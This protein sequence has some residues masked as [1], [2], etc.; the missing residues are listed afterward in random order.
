MTHVRDTKL[1]R[2]GPAPS[3]M[4]WGG[5]A[6]GF[7]LLEI[8]VV[9]ALMFVV[10]GMVINITPQIIRTA[11][12]SSSTLQVKSFLGKVREAAVTR[13]RNIE[14][15]FE[16]PNRLT[17]EERPI[18]GVPVSADRF[19]ETIT[20]EGNLEYVK[21]ADIP[22]TP[23]LFGMAAAV[24]TNGAAMVLFTSEGTFTD[25]NGDFVNVTLGF[26]RPNEPLTANAITI[27]G[28]TA[29]VRHWRWNGTRWNQ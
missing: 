28:T 7:T 26:A 12:G 5:A 3:Q 27:L 17:A 13:R 19:L 18:A 1:G 2:N 14:L 22:D 4:A 24:N 25:V 8:L 16:P 29:A 21:F 11:K 23:D 6:R 20:F 15:R 9:M 10:G